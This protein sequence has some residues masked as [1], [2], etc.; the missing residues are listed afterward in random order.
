MDE[1]LLSQADGPQEKEEAKRTRTRLINRLAIL[2]DKAN[3]D[4]ISNNDLRRLMTEEDLVTACRI[5]RRLGSIP[6][7]GSV[8]N[9]ADAFRRDH[10]VLERLIQYADPRT[11]KK[12]FVTDRLPI[13][14]HLKAC[15]LCSAQVRYFRVNC[16][17]INV[18]PGT[19]PD[20]P[21]GS[22]V[23][24][25]DGLHIGPVSLNDNAIGWVPPRDD[26]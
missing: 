20:R 4:V 24:D 2:L 13:E 8:Y 12:M 23:G 10:I 1:M 5:L 17:R 22:A 7:G 21:Q 16:D 25:L 19:A 14:Q 26:A 11:L 9:L 15:E 3:V 6:D 18:V